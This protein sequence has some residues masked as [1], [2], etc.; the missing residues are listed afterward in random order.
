MSC[1]HFNLKKKTNLKVKSINLTLSNQS[2]NLQLSHL[3]L[4]IIYYF[5]IIH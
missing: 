3:A 1:Q 2:F 5:D 4:I